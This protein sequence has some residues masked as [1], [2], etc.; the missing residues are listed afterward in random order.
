M[1]ASIYNLEF[2]SVYHFF[3]TSFRIGRPKR[4]IDLFIK[5]KT[6]EQVTDIVLLIVNKFKIH[7]NFDYF[8]Q[9]IDS[10][11]F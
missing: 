11:L 7:F 5:N 9:I 3:N 8:A 4:V 2:S 6:C 1:K 10:K